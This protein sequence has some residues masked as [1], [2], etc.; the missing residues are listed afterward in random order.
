M[1]D[2]DHGHGTIHND[3]KKKITFVGPILA[4]SGTHCRINGRMTVTFETQRIPIRLEVIHFC[5]PRTIWG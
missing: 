3:I 2:D 5:V 4:L 1:L